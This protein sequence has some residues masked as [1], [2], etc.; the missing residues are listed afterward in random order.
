MTAAADPNCH[1]CHSVTQKQNII[2]LILMVN[3]SLCSRQT[4]GLPV[5][6]CNA[7]ARNNKKHCIRQPHEPCAYTAAS[8]TFHFGT[9]QEQIEFPHVFCCSARRLPTPWQTRAHALFLSQGI[10]LLT[11]PP[12]TTG[13]T[14]TLLLRQPH[15][16]AHTLH[17][18]RGCLPCLY[19]WLGY[20]TGHRKLA[21]CAL[22]LILCCPCFLLPYL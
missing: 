10:P 14:V 13:A 22:A 6:H 18:W 5:F 3:P 16:T 7:A 12:T 11:P 8:N 9:S 4:W 2:L 1:N 21:W 19:H 17:P 15:H 20:S